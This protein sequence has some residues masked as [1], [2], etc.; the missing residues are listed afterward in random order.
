M[1]NLTLQALYA[2]ICV[3]NPSQIFLKVSLL[4]L[5]RRLFPGEKT[6]RICNG[7]LIFIPIWG[8]TQEFLAGLACIPLSLI[9]PSM[10]DHCINTL[11]IW[12]LT[13]VMNIVTDFVIFFI[14]IPSII[15]LQLK[16]VPKYMLVGLF[17]LGFL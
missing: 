12:Y 5:F 6:Q 10:A 2:T 9:V 7:L 17:G 15:R 13:S 1:S 11:P 3:Y 8:V 16:K 14:P 4:L